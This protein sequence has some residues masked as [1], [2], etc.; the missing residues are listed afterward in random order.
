VPLIASEIVSPAAPSV[1][2]GK[3]AKSWL[4]LTATFLEGSFGSKDQTTRAVERGAG[5]TVN[6]IARPD[7]VLSS[8][9]R[10]RNLRSRQE[11]PSPK[12]Q[13]DYIYTAK[14]SNDAGQL[15]GSPVPNVSLALLP[16]RDSCE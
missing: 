2:L 13:H 9:E 7:D 10:R 4:K 14:D 6:T 1:K 15:L 16:K 11:H 5:N 3:L 8:D 12:M